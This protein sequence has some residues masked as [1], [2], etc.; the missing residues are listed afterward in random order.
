MVSSNE[1]DYGPASV[2]AIKIKAIAME[3]EVFVNT[4][5]MLLVQST[6]ALN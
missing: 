2:V 5:N 1:K 3:Y 4:A 6:N